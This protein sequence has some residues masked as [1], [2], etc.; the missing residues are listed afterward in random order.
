MTR[1]RP[2]QS[3]RVIAVVAAGVVS[4]WV[5]D[6][7]VHRSD[8]PVLPRGPYLGLGLWNSV[9]ATVLLLGTDNSS[10]AARAGGIWSR[11]SP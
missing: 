7:V 6:F 4:H 2:R 11:W 3:G 1:R 5:L 9:P 10:L 8:M